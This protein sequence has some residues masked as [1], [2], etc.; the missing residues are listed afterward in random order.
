MGKPKSILEICFQYFATLALV[1][2]IA[3]YLNEIA[4]PSPPGNNEQGFP[5]HYCWFN[6]TPPVLNDS[7]PP[8]Y[9]APKSSG[10][11]VSGLVLDLIFYSFL[12]AA[13]LYILRTL[14]FRFRNS[15]KMDL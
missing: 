6:T 15:G 8:G 9:I 7:I 14:F 3:F 4:F 5:F 1:L 10:W 2:G 12:S 11:I 13:L